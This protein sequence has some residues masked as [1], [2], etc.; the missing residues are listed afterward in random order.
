MKIERS[1]SEKFHGRKTLLD[2]EVEASV[3]DGVV[4]FRFIYVD[5]PYDTSRRT[6]HDYTVQLSR[7]DILEI[8]DKLVLTPALGEGDPE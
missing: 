5:D 4:K 7:S 6:H 2:R 8:F 1:G 3:S